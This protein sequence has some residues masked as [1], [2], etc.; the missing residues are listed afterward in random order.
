V[1]FFSSGCI[2][3]SKIKRLQVEQVNTVY[4]GKLCG[5][6]GFSRDKTLITVKINKGK[7]EPWK[8]DIVGIAEFVRVDEV[9]GIVAVGPE[10]KF[11]SG[12]Q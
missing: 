8:S 10:I 12:K 2:A 9:L 3:N 5:N 6:K 4:V 1:I 7:N 11:N